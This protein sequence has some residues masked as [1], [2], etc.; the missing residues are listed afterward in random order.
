MS[1][2][3]Q[4]VAKLEES[5]LTQKKSDGLLYDFEA[6]KALLKNYLISPVLIKPDFISS[7]LILSLMR[8]PLTHYLEISY[9]VP[10]QIASTSNNQL[11]ASAA[12]LLERGLFIEFWQLKANSPPEL[13]DSVSGFVVGIRSFILQSLQDTFKTISLGLFQQLLGFANE[14]ENLKYIAL[15]ANLV[16]VCRTHINLKLFFNIIFQG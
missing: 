11:I 14:Q 2:G 13:F 8:L 5:V 9:I 3:P 15:N 7:V 10:V 16:Q 6:N 4:V 1:F 12:N